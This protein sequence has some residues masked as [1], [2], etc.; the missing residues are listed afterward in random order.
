MPQCL[1]LFAQSVRILLCLYD[2]R[3]Q[4]ALFLCNFLSRS[5]LAG[6]VCVLLT[7]ACVLFTQVCIFLLGC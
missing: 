2:F 1:L 6:Q 3:V 5:Q 4:S 7:Q